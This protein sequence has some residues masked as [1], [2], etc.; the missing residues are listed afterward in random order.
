MLPPCAAYAA[1]LGAML[2]LAVPAG[3]RAQGAPY[4]IDGIMAVTGP[5]A[6]VG[7]ME[8]RTLGVIEGLVNRGG[9][10]KGRPIKFVILDDQS[11]PQLAVQLMTGI[12]AKNVPVVIGPSFTATCGATLPLVAKSGP[13]AY[14]TTPGIHPEAGSYMFSATIATTDQ[15]PILVRYFH[16][17]GWTRIAS[18]TSND[19]TGQDVERQLDAVLA[20]PENRT[21]Q[22]VA[23]EHFNPTDLSVTAQMQHIRASNAQ[24]LFTWSTGTPFGTLLHGIRDAGIDLP[25]GASSGN[26]TY[27]PLEQYKTFL[28]AELYFPAGR[29]FSIEPGRGAVHDAQVVYFNALKAAGMKPEIG[30]SAV[31]DPAML[32][33]DALRHVGTDATAEQIRNYLE[34]VK[35]WTG[36]AGTYDFTDREHP[37]RG[38]G[39]NEGIM[40]RWDPVKEQFAI[41]SKVAGYLK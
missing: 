2:L 36:I 20:L 28:P 19:A 29:G 3:S 11:S 35:S 16:E 14:C 24:A 22:L 9:G 33:I 6:A 8:A 39:Q 34:G 40:Y 31:W 18:I 23:R 7:S 21:M 32:V 26:M 13:V 37:N 17:R 12:S 15:A 25:V 30:P 41:V 4:E 10:I 38:L 1:L 27:A 5:F